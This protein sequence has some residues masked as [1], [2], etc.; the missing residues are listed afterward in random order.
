MDFQPVGDSGDLW[1]AQADASGPLG[2]EKCSD[3]SRPEKT[4]DTGGDVSAE[5][6]LLHTTPLHHH[7]DE[8]VQPLLC[9][10][11]CLWNPIRLC[12]DLLRF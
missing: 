6:L 12:T 11:V 5:R 3:T 8:N 7:T 4:L 2:R 9:C 1:P 10:Q